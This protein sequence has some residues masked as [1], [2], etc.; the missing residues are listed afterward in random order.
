MR[1]YFLLLTAIL[2]TFSAISQTFTGTGG[3]IPGISTTRTCFSINVSGVGNINNTYGLASLCLNITHP[4]DD[5][6]EVVLKAPDGTTIPITIQNGGSGNNYTNTCFTG[7]ATTPI[8]FGTAPFTGSFLPEGYLGA[9]NNGQNANG[10]WQLCIQDRRGTGNSGSLSNWSLTFNN[11]PAPPPPA[12]P[13]CANNLPSTSSCSTATLICDFNGQCGSTAGTTTQAWPGLSSAACFGLQNN[14]FIQFIASATTASFSVWVPTTENTYNLGG[15][16][17]LFFSGPCNASTVNTFGCYPHI[18]AYET[19]GQ[20]IISIVSASGLTPGN[21][22][23]L[24][25]DGFNSDHCTFTIAANS[26]VNILDITPADPIICEGS[27]VNLSASGGNGIYSWSPAGFL[28]ATSGTTVT[29]NPP[30]TTTYTVSSTTATGCPLTK[31]VTVTINPLPVAATLSSTQPTC[32]NATGIITITA[33][34]GAGLQ[35]SIDGINYQPGTIFNNV[36]PGNYNVIVENT[37]TGCKSVATGI[38]INPAPVVPAAPTVTVTAQPTCTT[39]TGTITITAPTGVN[40]QYSIDGTTYQ[41][42]PV[43]TGIAP[44]TYNVTVQNTSSSCISN[45]SA[46]TVNPV[47]AAPVAPTAN[48]TIQPTCSSPTGTVTITAPVGANLQYSIDGINYQAGTVFTNLSPGNYQVYVQ[49]TA[50]GC[51]S[52][53]TTVTVN[54]TPNAPATPTVSVTAQPTCTTATGTITITAPTGANLQYSINGTTYQPGL[55]FN[56]VPPGNYNVTVQNSST[57]CTSAAASVTVNA[58]PASPAA[59]AASVT[60]QPNCNTATG[61][62]VITS[63]TGAN[64]QYS[65]NG[66]TYQPGTSFNNVTPGNYNVTVQNNITGCISAATL[67]TI[68]A[69]PITPVAPTANVTAQPTCIITTGTITVTAPTGANFQYSLDGTTFQSSPIFSGIVPGNYSISVQQLPSGCISAATPVTVNAVPNPPAAANFTSTQPTCTT[70]T[71][72]IL[73]T[74]P[75]GSNLEYSLDG[76]NYQSST[77]F[78]NLNTGNYNITVHNSVTGCTSA[79]TPATINAAPIAPATPS[80]SISTAPTCTS[81]VGSITVTAPLGLD[82]QYS[83]N[84]AAYQSSPVF[85]T[86][87]AGNYSITVQHT[88]SNCISAASSITMPVA[89]GA[90]EIPSFNIMNANCTNATGSISITSPIGANLEYS[91][92]GGP[93]QMATTFMNLLPG[94]YTVTARYIGTSCISSHPIAFLKAANPADCAGPDIYFPTIFTP[95]GD[96]QNDGFGPGPKSN[97]ALVKGYILQVYNRY[98]EKVFESRDPYE[99]WNGRYHGKLSANYNYTWVASYSYAGKQLVKK[100]NVIILK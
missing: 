37:G 53:A 60:T 92:N 62:I 44:G 10:T 58:I 75:V 54:A 39:P 91:L 23:Y 55:N 93:F 7:T 67:L 18:L 95:N 8:K 36:P 9:A 29:A 96:G 74:S 64:L 84:G 48:V 69:A 52:S 25:I 83:L 5:E 63:P 43:F 35:Y 57:G 30:S 87:P 89:T 32:S 16:Q 6:L 100:G 13:A 82:L 72:S 49:H 99:Q 12:L 90:P 80:L 45:A 81:P 56:N 41:T 50:T 86:L 38:T 66:T 21:T 24:M 11:T 59:P 2:F 78:P 20:P 46:V 19:P 65:I 17:M 88:T 31:D 34:I 15:I 85:N 51:I 71:G 40:L 47:P 27:S 42:S 1:I 28:S 94:G 61:T 73:I 3:S 97:L 79:S 98:G 77:N 14:S 70:S 33:P 26:G 76:I 22:Y 68:N 4:Y